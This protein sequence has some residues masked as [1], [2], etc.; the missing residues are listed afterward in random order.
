MDGKIVNL[1]N[2][3][4]ERESEYEKLKET[5]EDNEND[6]FGF[7]FQ[8][9]E[10][11][12]TIN[13][14]LENITLDIDELNLTRESAFSRKETEKIPNRRVE[15]LQRT[16]ELLLTELSKANEKYMNERLSAKKLRHEI[17]KLSN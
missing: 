13:G 12:R 11:M 4:F 15:E 2:F 3:L 16:N 5:I 14:N 9:D 17:E 6:K 7:I 10:L 8:T 1:M